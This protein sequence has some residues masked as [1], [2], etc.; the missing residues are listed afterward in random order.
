MPVLGG[1]EKEAYRRPMGDEIVKYLRQEFGREQIKSTSQVINML[2]DAE[3][4]DEYA[5]ALTEYS[6]SGI[7]PRDM[8]RQL[9]ER[10]EVG[11]VLYTRLL[12]DSDMGL[13]YDGWT[14]AQAVR[15]DE[16][17]VQSQVWD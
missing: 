1:A 12:G 9:G 6:V 16:L 15:V 11:Y 3:L 17:Y 13:V 5:T 14:G 7:V 8:V 10:M 2:N 4:S